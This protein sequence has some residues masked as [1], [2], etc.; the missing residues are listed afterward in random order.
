MP[1]REA[2]K[3]TRL[4]LTVGASGCGIT[5]LFLTAEASAGDFTDLSCMIRFSACFGLT[6]ITAELHTKHSHQDYLA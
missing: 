1:N 5:W 3:K 4:P 2:T 6:S